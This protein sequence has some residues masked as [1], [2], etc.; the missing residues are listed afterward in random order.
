MLI[1]FCRKAVIHVKVFVQNILSLSNLL[2]TAGQCV[3]KDVFSQF[4]HNCSQYRYDDFINKGIPARRQNS[5]RR[6]Q[7][8]I[9]SALLALCDGNSPANSP[10][11]GRWHGAV[12]VS[13]ICVWTNSSVNNRDAGDLRRHRAHYDVNVILV[14]EVSSILFWECNTQTIASNVIVV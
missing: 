3:R 5:W 13:L 9:F 6:H 12:M 1:E 7:M 14:V 11:K 8:E 10:H 4:Q 2:N